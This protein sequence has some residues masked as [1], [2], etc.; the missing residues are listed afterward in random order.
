MSLIQICDLQG[1]GFLSP[2]ANQ[3][4]ETIGVVTG[5]LR[6][7]FFIQTPNKDWD[8]VSS[9]AIF[10]FSP[11]WTVSV[12]Y[13][14]V[15]TGRCVDFI[16]HDTAKPVTQIH[17]K[18]ARV[19]STR[20]ASINPIE[21]TRDFLPSA[22]DELAKRLNA[23][24]GMLVSVAQ[25]QT[26]IAPS[27]PFGDYVLALDANTK[28]DSMVRSPEGGA[29]V[30]EQNPL[31]WFPG[32]RVT[33]YHNAQRLNVGSTLKSTITGPLNYRVD[34]YQIAVNSAFDVEHNYIDRDKASLSS[35]NGSITI[36]TLNCFNLDAHVESPDR[37]MNPQKD[38]DDDFGEGRFHTLAQAV[39]LEANTPDIVALQEIQDNDGAEISAVIDAS[40][41]YEV[42]IN[43]IKE[44]SGIEYQWADVP[45]QVGEDGG[46]PGGNI[47]N[48]YLYNP[49]RVSIDPQSIRVFATEEACFTNSRKPLIAEFIEKASEKRLAVINVHLASKRHQSSIFAVENAGIDSKE[50]IRVD[51]ARLIRLEAEK[52]LDKGVEFYITGDFNDL[53]FS[54][55]ML[56]C[57]G[58]R[59][60]N[61]VLSLPETERYDYNHRGKLQVLMHGI[62]PKKMSESG[63]AQYEIIHGNELIGVQP[64]QEND[65]PSDHAYVLAKLE[66]D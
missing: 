40:K 21:L 58:E 17:L 29:I 11:D 48:A 57:T 55:T 42:L 47:R 44:L 14:V 33:N 13:E 26:F 46:Q 10:V 7:G 32:F 23:L 41:T 2:F 28:D 54:P 12:G 65:K 53:E 37:V 1:D 3:E 5:V 38:V 6:R 66:L 15:V 59:G 9:D 52:S 61:L 45:P 50:H 64:G 63:R 51:Q 30:S 27:N 4:I 8:G 16:K 20:G 19:K 43:A 60:V 18:E 36:M 62:V 39:V 56:E 35:S 31:R 22:N 49:E 25:G 24:E 34:A